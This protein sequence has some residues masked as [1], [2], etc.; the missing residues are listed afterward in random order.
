[1]RH[2]IFFTLLLSLSLIATTNTLAQNLAEPNLKWGHPTQQELEMT[3]YTPDPDADAVVLCKTT[4]VHYIITKDVL[5]VLYEVKGRIKILKP[6]G[7]KH[8]NVDIYYIVND[9]AEGNREEVSQVKGT[10]FNIVNGQLDRSELTSNMINTIKASDPN[11]KVL[12]LLFP[13]AKVGSIIEYEYTITSDLYLEVKDWVA[14][15]EMP[16]AYTKYDVTIPEWFGF[17][18]QTIGNEY[19]TSRITQQRT[20]KRFLYIMETAGSEYESMGV[21]FV[22][23]GRKLTPL[24][25]EPLIFS[26]QAY[27]QRVIIDINNESLPRRTK[28]QYS[29]TWDEIDQYLLKQNNFG[30]LLKSNPFKKEMKKA[31]IYQI[32]NID[33]KITA[34]AKLLRQHVKWN[35]QYSLYGNPTNQVLKRGTGSNS[36]INF[37]FIAMLNDAGIN[38]YPAVLSYRNC[39]ILDENHPT[40]KTLSSSIAVIDRGDKFQVFDGSVEN[41]II[42]I[43]PTNFLVSKARIIKKEN[44]NPWINLEDKGIERS[45]YK[46]TG[47]INQNGKLTATCISTHSD[48]A[49]EQMRSAIRSSIEECPNKKFQS[50]Q[51]TVNGYKAQG[52]DDI[53]VPVSEIINFSSQLNCNDGIITLPQLIVPFIDEKLFKSETRY[54]P[55]EFPTK[56]NETIDIAFTIPDGWEVV[57]V[58]APISLNTSDNSI[59]MTIT[60][61]LTGNTV[62]VSSQ[63]LINRL[64]F[65]K[66]D[67]NGIKNLVDRIVKQSKEPFIIKKK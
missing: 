40:M 14:Q 53:E 15:C 20:N 12:S 64:V 54:N 51:I 56:V 50:S 30:K 61:S 36:D 66:R 49:A 34:I 57:D 22:F 8:A 59:I 11:Q 28:I 10:T 33:E 1:M 7:I 39:D 13:D 32:N 65:N 29:M 47:E 9:G 27:A 16:V 19:N 42:D 55:I 43:L 2:T 67:Y 41:A 31:G 18:V 26:P 62:K 48:K 38:A 6:E 21:N 3:E 46:I 44:N 5:Q 52:L 17:Y 35:G 45:G 23:E 4:N 24:K 58:P 25:N 37:M 63:L 60:P